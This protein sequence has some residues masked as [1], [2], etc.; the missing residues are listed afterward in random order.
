MAEEPPTPSSLHIK[1]PDDH[2]E[3]DRSP[4]VTIVVDE[5]GKKKKKLKSSALQLITVTVNKSSSLNICIPPVDQT[6]RPEDAD[7]DKADDANAG[8][9]GADQLVAPH[10][11]P[12]PQDHNTAKAPNATPVI[13]GRIRSTRTSSQMYLGIKGCRYDEI[14][15]AKTKRGQEVQIEVQYEAMEREKDGEPGTSWV[16]VGDNSIGN[17]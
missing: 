7:G 11:N 12:E 2:P 10:H 3:L 14:F 9:D 15:Y 4:D 6:D 5:S 13:V 17:G 8:A 16:V 1:S